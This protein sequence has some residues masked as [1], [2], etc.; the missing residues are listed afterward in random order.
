MGWPS[1]WTCPWWWCTRT[2]VVGPVTVPLCLKEEAAV[3]EGRSEALWC[4]DDER[5]RGGDLAVVEV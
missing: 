1:G 4:P 2:F 3:V 5:M